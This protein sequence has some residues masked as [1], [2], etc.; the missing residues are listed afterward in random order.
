M[1]SGLHVLTLSISIDIVGHYPD[2]FLVIAKST[3]K[4]HTYPKLQNY[5]SDKSHY[6]SKYCT[7]I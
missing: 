5:L 7:S 2:S 1:K 3:A 4:L 6:H